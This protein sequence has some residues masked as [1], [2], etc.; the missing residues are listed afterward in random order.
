MST[1]KTDDSFTAEHD[2]T[3]AAAWIER[4]PRQGRV[5]AG[6]PEYE[7]QPELPAQKSKQVA[8]A[9][10]GSKIMWKEISGT[11]KKSARNTII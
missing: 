10:L 5:F 3:V 9:R 1:F 6:C 8:K 2:D 7:W 11:D 4:L